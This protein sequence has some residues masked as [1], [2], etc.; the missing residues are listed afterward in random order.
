[1][2]D[3]LLAH[4]YFLS[5]DTKQCE[6]MRPYP[7]LATLYAAEVLRDA[8]HEVALFDAMLADGEHEFADALRR[9][10]P[11]RRAVRGQLQL[12]VEDVPGADARGRAHDG[13][14]G[15]QAAAAASRWP[16]PT[17]PITPTSISPRAPTS[18]CSARAS[19]PPAR[20]SPRGALAGASPTTT[21]ID[22]IA[23]A[24]TRRGVR[25]A[26]RSD[27][28][29]PRRRSVARH[30]TSSTSRRYRT[31][32]LDSHGRFSLNM[33]STRGLPVPLQLVRQADL[34]PA[35]RDAHAG[36]RRRG[37]GCSEGR[38]S[39]R[40]TSGSPTTSSVCAATGWPSSPTRSSEARRGDAVH[41]AVALRPHDTR[42]GGRVGA[43]PAATRCGSA[44]R[45]AASG[46]STRWTRGSPSPRFAA[47]GSCARRGRHPRLPLHP[48]RI[49]R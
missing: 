9:H 2:S 12:P 37:N 32:W 3:V 29:A 27:R 6:K 40:T 25:T 46:C 16:A 48:V 35:L 14:H 8:G 47:P 15:E 34:G 23:Y 20:S 31:A 17:S 44:P 43:S 19:T 7:P 49:S 22:G 21:A 11:R 1:M 4:S 45:A 42:G 39:A 28:A 10:R 26:R 38:V 5:L 30:G 36:R 13:D 33:V 41:D 24:F 18:A